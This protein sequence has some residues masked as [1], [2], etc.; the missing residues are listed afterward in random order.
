MVELR[1]TDAAENWRQALEAYADL[2]RASTRLH[3]SVTRLLSRDGDALV[4]LKRALRSRDRPAAVHVIRRLDTA[5]L[6]QLFPELVYLATFDH[7]DLSTVRSTIRRIPRSWLVSHLDAVAREHLQEADDAVYRRLL[8]LYSG[9]DFDLAV[10]LATEA[11]RSDDP[12]IKEVGSDFLPLPAPLSAAPAQNVAGKARERLNAWQ[13]HYRP[14][15]PP[16]ARDWSS[17][18]DLVRWFG[19]ESEFVIETKHIPNP[20][21]GRALTA[22]ARDFGWLIDWIDLAPYSALAARIDA[23]GRREDRT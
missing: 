17:A 7:P 12:E 19:P 20:V 16:M 14:K 8:E 13:R 15:A 10:Q 21:V 11:A 3:S 9:I 23:D 2:F 4:I 18:A 22:A 6:K 1:S 5:G